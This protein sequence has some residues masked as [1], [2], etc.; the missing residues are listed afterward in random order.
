MSQYITVEIRLKKTRRWVA[1]LIFNTL[2]TVLNSY[3]ISEG[4]KR[5]LLINFIM[6]NSIPKKV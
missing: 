2:S 1:F 5:N 4:Y 3:L 6:L